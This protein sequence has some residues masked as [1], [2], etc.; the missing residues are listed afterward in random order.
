MFVELKDIY[1]EGLVHISTLPNDYYQ[2]DPTKQAL[3]GERS[4]R[5]FRLG[6]LIKVKVVRV[7]LDQRQIDFLLAD[8]EA[9]TRPSKVSKQKKSPKKKRR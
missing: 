4:G 1:V 9:P 5:R 7:D 8:E 3:L 2:F 6:D